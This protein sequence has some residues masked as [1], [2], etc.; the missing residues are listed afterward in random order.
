MAVPI[1]NVSGAHPMYLVDGTGTAIGGGSATAPSF[2][3]IVNAKGQSGGM[4]TYSVV[5]TGYAA[6]ATP[7]DLLVLQGSASKT[8]IVTQMILAVNTTATAPIQLFFIKRTTANTGGTA[9][10]SAGVSADSQNAVASAVLSIY[11]AAPTTGSVTGGGNIYLANAN[12][13]A[14]TGSP[15]AI[16]LQSATRTPPAG[17]SDFR[18]GIT[19]RGAGESLAINF[20]GAALPA[21]FT[22]TYFVEWVEF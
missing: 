3:Q 7:T 13:A 16:G 11:T 14:T 6:Y 5:G 20:G 2:S 1:D 18:Q 21:G 22:A 12:S 19:L 9:T 17:I 8:I 4:A 10:T 15:N